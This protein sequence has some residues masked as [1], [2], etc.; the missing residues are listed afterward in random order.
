MPGWSSRRDE[1]KPPCRKVADLD[2]ETLGASITGFSDVACAPD[3]NL[4][5]LE[6]RSERRYEYS[7][8]RVMAQCANVTRPST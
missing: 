1:W 8:D 4:Y 2:V 5:W 3:V 6:S 7:E